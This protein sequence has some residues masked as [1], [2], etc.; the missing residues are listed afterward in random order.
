[1]KNT[2]NRRTITISLTNGEIEALILTALNMKD[3]LSYYKYMPKNKFKEFCNAYDS[4]INKLE[5]A[6]NNLHLNYEPD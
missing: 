1:M 2:A 6:K 3:D 4:A 5:S